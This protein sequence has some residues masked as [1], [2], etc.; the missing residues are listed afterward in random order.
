MTDQ[1][2]RPRPSTRIGQIAGDSDGW[3][4]FNR[5]RQMIA[6][7]RSVTELTQGEH[8]IPTDPSILDAMAASARGGATGYAPV[9]GEMRLRDVVAARLTERTGVP[10]EARN[11]MITPGGQSALFAAHMA[12]CDPGDRALYIDPYYATY[13]G[14]IRAAGAQAVAVVTRP[15]DGFVPRK[16][17][18]AALAPGA[19][20]F[21]INSPNNPTGGVYSPAVLEQIAGIVQEHDL[22][23]ISDEVYDTQVWDGA[24]LSPRS[25]AGMAERVLVVGSMSKSHAMTG[26]RVGWIAG[27]APVIAHLIDLATVTTYGVPGFLQEAAVF[28]LG[29]GRAFEDRISAPFRRRRDIAARVL[30]QRRGLRLHRPEAAMYVMVDI[31]ATGLSGAAFANRL[32]DE[33]AIAV[34]PG[35]SFGV[36]TAGHL[37]IALTVEDAQLE[38]ALTVLG[39]MAD[40]LSETG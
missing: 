33:H 23:L 13:P 36:A 20:S 10:T 30:G 29:Q 18:L 7:G 16:A 35:E 15:E 27:P 6:E 5:S 21:L 2:Q 14:T 9:P 31:R 3:E 22:W 12:V 4:V 40:A 26:S 17:D 38:G 19:R 1:P 39:D 32:L 24:H 25:L 34:M 11:V 8:D 28:A 37:R